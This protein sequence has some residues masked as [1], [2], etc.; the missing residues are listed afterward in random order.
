MRILL[1]HSGAPFSTGDVYTG[2]K[3]GLETA[4][5]DIV[6]YRL[7]LRIEEAY[8]LQKRR[9]HRNRRADKKIK[10]TPMMPD[11]IKLASMPLLEAALTVMPHWIVVVSGMV[12]HPDTMILLKRM[13]APMA[14]VLTESPYDDD[15]Q[16]RRTPLFNLT[17][18]NERASV[19]LFKRWHRE[20]NGQI[21]TQ[22][23]VYLPHAYDPNVHHPNIEIDP[24][25]DKQVEAHD[26]VFVG[27]GFSERVEM[28][29]GVNW[30]RLGVNFGLY[31]HWPY[32]RRKSPLRPFLHNHIVPNA[33]TAALY[34][35]AKLGLN[36][37]RQSAGTSR[38]A[39]RISGA[40]SLNP[41]AL[42]LAAIGCPYISDY[43]PEVGE[44]FGDWVPTFNSPEE[45]ERLIADLMNDDARR[46]EIG[47]QL[48]VLSQS[49]T[50][51]ER[52]EQ[53]GSLL[54][55]YTRR[56]QAGV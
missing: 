33:I 3:Y 24:K 35:K 38:N 17:T 6:E 39:L 9:N 51:K 46:A 12:L 10:I 48:C 28:L 1:V 27:S 52:G 19:D 44:V 26:V 49:W 30:D 2:L 20:S 42:E 4:G 54:E 16:A 40:E 18:T 32:L 15:K 53:L 21:G 8:D 37:Y 22:D 13:D 23:I 7:D 47:R 50:Y 43:R 45:M 14:L 5:H 36:L 11:V 31:G 29:E 55:Q 41:R 25:T 56:R 34:S